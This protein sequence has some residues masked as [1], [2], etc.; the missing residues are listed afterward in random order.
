MTIEPEIL[1][2]YSN[3]GEN[4]KYLYNNWPIYIYLILSFVIFIVLL[5]FL[6]QII[7]IS[8]G[9]NFIWRLARYKIDK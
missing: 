1:P 5:K 8:L 2:E 7:L 6:F 9:L 4:S 3:D